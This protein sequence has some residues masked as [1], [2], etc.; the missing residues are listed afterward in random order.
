MWESLPQHLMELVVGKA[1]V[2]GGRRAV[3]SM[4]LVSSSWHAAIRAYPG[5]L[6]NIEVERP[7]QIADLQKIMP[8]VACLEVGSKEEEMDL[9][10]LSELT[11]LTSLKLGRLQRFWGVYATRQLAPYSADLSVLP[12][13]LR[14]L[15]LQDACVVPE[16][17]NSLTC[18]ELTSLSFAFGKNRKSDLWKLLR[19]LPKLKVQYY[20][21]SE[22]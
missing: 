5:T 4:R 14:R 18:S 3:A 2:V 6:R 13:S 20:P 17:I 9:G 21:S 16:G 7:S 11:R 8:E 22:A 10:L 15:Q 19:N 1:E 12:T